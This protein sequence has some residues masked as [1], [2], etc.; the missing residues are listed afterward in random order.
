MVRSDGENIV[1]ILEK[2]EVVIYRSFLKAGLR[3]PPHKMLAE[4]LKRFE[5]YLHQITL[6]AL[7]KVGIFIWAV[8][9][10]GLELD[11]Y[12]FCNIHELIYQTKDIG[13]EQYHN[14][15]GCYTFVYRS[16]P[17][18]PSPTF[19]QKWPGS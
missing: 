18:R 3:F 1:P 16:D 15:F 19:Q 5:I 4:V 7:I 17:S 10:Q 11:A 12:C 6:E 13:K 2:D 9:S 8:R 14:N